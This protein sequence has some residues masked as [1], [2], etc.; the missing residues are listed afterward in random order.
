MFEEYTYDAILNDMLSE[1]SDL[2]KQEGSLIFIA[3]SKQAARLEQAYSDLSYIADNMYPDT[4]DL[5][6]LIMFGNE[7]GIILEEGTPATIKGQ[8][9]MEIKLGSEFEGDDYNYIATDVLDEKNHIYEMEC[10]EN[11]IDGNH[12]S[13]PMDIEALEFIDG[14]EIA[15]LTEFINIGTDDEE[16]ESYRQRILEYFGE[17]PFAG[18]IAYYKELIDDMEGVGGCRPKRRE[19]STVD[20]V[21]INS[22]YGIPGEELVEMVQNEVDPGEG[23]GTGIAPI[24]HS[25]LIKA[26]TG[27]DVDII[28]SI[29]FENNYTFEG[30]KTQIEDAVKEYFLEYAKG[31]E[32]N[33]KT[34]IYASQVEVRLLQIEGI[35]DIYDTKINGETRIKFEDNQIPV[36]HSIKLTEV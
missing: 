17:K 20:I 21:I 35:A 15:E 1:I 23:G 27:V 30:I 19:E 12:I 22:S 8:F 9:N 33:E 26:V 6:H 36:F 34:N 3:L 16:E 7:I 14:L 4:A 24:G 5:E 32:S 31:W 13:L 28:S 10:T 2:D 18:N 11:G 25:V 29:D